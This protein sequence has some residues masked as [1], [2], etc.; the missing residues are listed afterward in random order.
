MIDKVIHQT[1]VM[2]IA[3]KFYHSNGGRLET[4]YPV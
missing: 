4:W 3:E 1:D 2:Q